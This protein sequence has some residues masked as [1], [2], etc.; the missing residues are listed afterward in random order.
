MVKEQVKDNR[1]V[2]SE[3]TCVNDKIVY[4]INI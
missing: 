4:I 2:V 1:F 3:Y